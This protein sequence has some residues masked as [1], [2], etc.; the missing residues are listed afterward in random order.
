MSSFGSSNS[1]AQVEDVFQRAMDLPRDRRAGLLDQLCEN[2]NG[3]RREV[4]ELLTSHEAAGTRFEQ[5]FYGPPVT[6]DDHDPLRIGD[7]TVCRRLGRGGMAVVFEAVQEQP[8]RR[9][10]I[11]LIR[12]DAISESLR[13]RFDF[14][15]AA[16]ARLRHQ[17]IAHIY[18]AGMA[19]VVYADGH[20]SQQPFHAME[21]VEG[22]S[23]VRHA[24][25][26]MLGIEQRL[27]L[28]LKVCDAIQHAHQNGIIHRDL[29]PANILVNAA[30][31]PKIL[32]FGVAR[33]TT[34]DIQ[35]S[36]QHTSA[37]QLIGTLSYMSPEQARGD[38]SQVDTRTDVYALGAILYE[39]LCGR[40]LHDLTNLALHDAVRTICE[41]VPVGL[42]SI[43]R[44][45][46][47]DLDTIIAK[48]IEKDASRRFQSVAEFAADLLRYL[49]HEP[50]TARPP[51]TLYVLSRFARRN[52]GVVIGAG[53]ALTALL[54]GAVGTATFAWRASQQAERA[55]ENEAQALASAAKAE[56]VVQ[57]LLDVVR[58]PDPELAR[59]PGFT[60]RELLDEVSVQVGDRFRNQPELLAAVR[61]AVGNTYQ[62]IGLREKA[63]PQLEEALQIRERLHGENHDDVAESLLALAGLKAECGELQA[64]EALLQRALLTRRQLLGAEHPRVADVLVELGALKED[65]Q[66]NT[67]AEQLC[68]EALRVYRLSG[69]GDAPGVG[70]CLEQLGYLDRAARRYAEAEQN[71]R[72]ALEHYR[73][74]FGEHHPTVFLSMK[75]LAALLRTVKRYDEAETLYQTS[76]AGVRERLGPDH[77]HVALVLNSL[78]ILRQ[79]QGRLDEADDLFQQAI[80]I[81]RKSY[82]GDA[83]S[84]AVCLRN[85]AY[86]LYKKGDPAQAAEYARMA[87]DMR[88][89]M[90]TESHETVTIGIN[91]VAT[92][93]VA[94]GDAAAAADLC[95]EGIRRARTE[96]SED[97]WILGRRL[98]D[99]GRLL[100][101]RGGTSEE[102][103]LLLGEAEAVLL[104]AQDIA[105]K[106]Y[107]TN[108]SRA[109]WVAVTLASLYEKWDQPELAA[110][111]R[112]TAMAG[113]PETTAVPATGSTSDVED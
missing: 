59:G 102:G 20:V 88:R 91:S 84:I 49:R 52:R 16:L 3:L 101:A 17:G 68:R 31:Q 2:D 39:L 36:T 85:Y 90:H 113:R 98:Y 32:D 108:R 38:G 100:I 76:L 64:A 66:R 46:R 105:A 58:T 13:R 87:L 45:L 15:S 72:D 53:L 95:R 61:A 93:L 28:F 62:A 97:R 25:S 7:Y 71:L 65:Q 21:L 89:R 29:K 41:S 109:Y 103:R 82:A 22:E 80:A 24:T 48:A 63:S 10:A 23:L 107:P 44:K 79:A 110:R 111:W 8:N 30:G 51:S 73:R 75:N 35:T 11:K 18:A 12:P 78:A 4:E 77:P 47:G 9:V 96:T 27:G 19:D 57:M 40:S 50:V 26:M 37:G 34:P 6:G 60:M 81:Y 69:G 106:Y 94:A 54:I 83:V 92:F 42:G 1:Y 86:L 104:E 5:P 112:T 55:A 67:E 74:R 14:E 43:D 56:A 33:I 70:K 99:F